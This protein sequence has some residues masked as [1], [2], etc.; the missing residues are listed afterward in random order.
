MLKKTALGLSVI[1]QPL[2][3]PTF[4]VATLFYIVPE[5]TMVPKGAKWAVLLLIGFT[6]F[7]VPLLSLLG[8]RY[9]AVINSLQLP[10]RRERI[11]PFALVS[12][13]YVMTVSFFYW[14][15]NIDQ[16]LLVTLGLVTVSLV[17]MTVV[18]FFYKIS[19]HQ[20]AMGGWVAIVGVLSVKF[21][22]GP[23]FYYFLLVIVLS[24]LIGTARLYLNAHR[25]S[26]VYAGFL[27][28]FGICFPV[29]YHLLIN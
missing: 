4:M 24:G 9:S 14:K 21:T 3:I 15:L 2:V 11:Y 27:L 5:A 1:F 16:L 23:M 6:T 17:L 10:N 22:S 13:F 29:Y 20:T 19:A 18:T 28:G 25:P 7:L 12:V 26:E 8:L